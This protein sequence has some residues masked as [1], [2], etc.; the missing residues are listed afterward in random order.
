MAPTTHTIQTTCL[1]PPHQTQ[2]FACGPP[3]KTPGVFFPSYF[4]GLG[5][6]LSSA[7][8]AAVPLLC[9]VIPPL[10]RR[11]RPPCP[12]DPGG[13][14]HPTRASRDSSSTSSLHF[15]LAIPTPPS[16]LVTSESPCCQKAASLSAPWSHASKLIP[17]P[18]RHPCRLHPP[19]RPADAVSPSHL[20]RPYIPLAPPSQPC[21]AARPPLALPPPPFLPPW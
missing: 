18:C 7:L 10:P 21:H 3:A 17:Y 4:P 14:P 20:F 15:T 11:V 12:D 16:R 19:P 6:G 9:P 1:E 2:P 8:I 13:Y 5:A